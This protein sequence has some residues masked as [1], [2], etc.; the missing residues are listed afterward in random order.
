MA[1]KQLNNLLPLQEDSELYGKNGTEHGKFKAGFLGVHNLLHVQDVKPANTGGGTFTAGA[2]R[3]R[4]LNTVVTNNI[5]G[6][7]LNA[8]NQA[9]LPAGTYMCIAWAPATAV[10]HHMLRLQVVSPVAMALGYGSGVF[11]NNAASVANMAM[12]SFHFTLDEQS[13]VE[14]QHACTATFIDA[15][16]GWVSSVNTTGALSDL[17]IWKLS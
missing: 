6:A 8:S 2:W 7:S 17:K 10:D 5:A 3:T 9:I 4:A 15:G 14:L 16:F 13:T 11:A 1:D 12:M